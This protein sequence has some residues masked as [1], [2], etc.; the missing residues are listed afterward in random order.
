VW[1]PREIAADAVRRPHDDRDCGC[2]GCASFD[3]QVSIRDLAKRCER[4]GIPL[5]SKAGTRT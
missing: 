4:D 1:L 3:A 2:A 5:P